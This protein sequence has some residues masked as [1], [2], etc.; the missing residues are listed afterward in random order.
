MEEAKKEEKKP[1]ENINL[2]SFA[3]DLGFSIAIPLVVFAVL[4]RLADKHWDISPLGL[5]SGLLLSVVI[6]CFLVYR[7]VKKIFSKIS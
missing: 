1:I 2:V 7:Q 3:F 5:L 4:G 6:S